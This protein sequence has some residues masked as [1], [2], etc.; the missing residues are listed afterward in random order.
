MI[1][2][3][4]ASFA[5]KQLIYC[6]YGVPEHKLLLPPKLFQQIRGMKVHQVYEILK[7]AAFKAV[8]AR[9]Q[10]IYKWMQIGDYNE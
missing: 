9:D 10:D 2:W 8:Q 3:I 1:Q 4:A 6:A 7:L 5:E